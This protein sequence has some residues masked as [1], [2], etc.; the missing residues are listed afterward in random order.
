M[1]DIFRLLNRVV[2]WLGPAEHDSAYAFEILNDLSTKIVVDWDDY[3]VK[4]ATQED[5]DVWCTDRGKELPYG[6][7]EFL[8][9]YH[10]FCRSWFTKLWVWQETHLTN[11]DAI[12]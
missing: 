10:L 5:S 1:A 11:Q 12:P 3:S 6:T 8:A 4:P 2:A 7:S 9:I